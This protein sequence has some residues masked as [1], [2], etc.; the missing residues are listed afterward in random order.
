M[1][2]D[3]MT[4]STVRTVES[5]AQSEGLWLDTPHPPHT[6]VVLCNDA[7][8]ED[9]EVLRFDAR[10]VHGSLEVARLYLLARRRERLALHQPAPRL[11]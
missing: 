3:D 1:T 8:G 7:R 10:T 6:S 2:W 9:E 5:L 4:R 11:P